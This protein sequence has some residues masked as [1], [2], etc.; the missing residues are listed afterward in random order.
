MRC[1]C[2]GRIDPSDYIDGPKFRCTK[3]GQYQSLSIYDYTTAD[4]GDMRTLGQECFVSMCRNMGVSR[5]KALE[6]WGPHQC[7]EHDTYMDSQ[8]IERCRNCDYEYDP[9]DM[10]QGEVCG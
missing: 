9:R 3:C 2:G 7:T 5:P 6:M 10:I 1:R 4:V 8:N